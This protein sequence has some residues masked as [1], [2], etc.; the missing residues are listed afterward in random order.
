MEGHRQ[1][2]GRTWL[3]SRTTLVSYYVDKGAGPLFQEG[4]AFSL[5]LIFW[6]KYASLLRGSFNPPT[7]CCIPAS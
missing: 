7:S 6:V 5:L 1:E 3:E 4:A 2:L